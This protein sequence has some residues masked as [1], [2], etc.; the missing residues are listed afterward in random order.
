MGKIEASIILD[1]YAKELKKKLKFS[2]LA[3]FGSFARG[4]AGKNSDIDAAVVISKL[5][6]DYLKTSALLWEIAIG[7]DTRIEPVLIE[8]KDKSG[9]L[10]EIL[11]YGIVIS[12][13]PAVR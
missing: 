5:K 6:G 11:K 10:E 3:L 13:K 4:K 9:F 1:A 7:I 12:G 8:E 2:R